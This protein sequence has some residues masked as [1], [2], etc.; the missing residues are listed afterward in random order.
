MN[1]KLLVSFFVCLLLFISTT[2]YAKVT[3]SDFV[4]GGIYIGQ[5]VSEAVSI[6]G[7]P[8]SIKPAVG[9]GY[10]YSYGQYDTIFDIHSYDREVVSGF[11][12]QGNNGATTKAGIKYGS[13][14][15]D[16]KNAYGEPDIANV[17]RNGNYVVEYEYHN[18]KFNVWVLHFEL[19]NGWVV[20]FSFG[21]YY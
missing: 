20:G 19:K 10:L 15:K 18:S 6:Y 21:S 5:P 11:Y 4:A 14:L 12:S 7:L 8:R 3:K 13:S 9:K 16:I 2:S 1:K 17:V